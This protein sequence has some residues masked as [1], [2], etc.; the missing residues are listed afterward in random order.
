MFYVNNFLIVV[1]DDSIVAIQF[2]QV[3]LFFFLFFSVFG[4]SEARPRVQLFMAI[5][6]K[7]HLTEKSRFK[8]GK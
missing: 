1:S 8:L 5:D 7:T 3:F 4:L 6:Y 2:L